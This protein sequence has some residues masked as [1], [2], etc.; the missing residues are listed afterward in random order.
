MRGLSVCPMVTSRGL[1][2]TFRLAYRLGLR[3]VAP[4][5]VVSA[6]GAQT[7][8]TVQ[9]P[10]DS[11]ALAFFGVRAGARLEELEARLRPR[12]GRLRCDRAKADPH[13]SECRGELNDPRLGG[14]VDLW[15]SAIDST[16][17]IITLSGPV[18][19]DQLA[20]WRHDIE[21][22]Y[23]KV[24]ARAQGSQWMMQWVRRGRM[25]RLTWR[26]D[27]NRKQASVSLVDG[28]LLDR[29]GKARSQPP[30]RIRKLPSDSSRT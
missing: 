4:L 23:G 1:V 25:L 29:W 11:S 26:I 22:R 20:Y 19:T 28:S 13:V 15:V 21:R 30:S 8:P 16:S 18:A 24:D 2:L 12:G 14:P 27:K 5:L 7:S 17:G 6:A 9:Q 10:A 3:L